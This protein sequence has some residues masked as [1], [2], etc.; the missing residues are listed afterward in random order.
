MS[1]VADMNCKGFSDS[2]SKLL[3]SVDRRCWGRVGLSVETPCLCE[4]ASLRMPFGLW[5]CVIFWYIEVVLDFIG[6]NVIGFV[7]WVLKRKVW[8]IGTRHPKGSIAMGIRIILRSRRPP[9]MVLPVAVV[10]VILSI[11]FSRPIFFSSYYCRCESALAVNI[12]VTSGEVGSK[13]GHGGGHAMG[14][15]KPMVV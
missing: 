2:E 5:K 14:T 4:L 1:R 9:M 3:E 8:R 11:L 12:V 6:V 10:S 13:E 7:G 15:S